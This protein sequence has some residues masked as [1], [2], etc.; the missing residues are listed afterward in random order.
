MEK[1][2]FNV[3]NNHTFDA[4]VYYLFSGIS[5]T[6]PFHTFGPAKRRDY[7]IHF[8]L[9][10]QG[11]FFTE[12][13]QF[14]LQAG[15]VFL[16]RP[17]ESCFYQS[18]IKKPWTYAWI[19]FNGNQAQQIIEHFSPFKNG[20]HVFNS[21]NQNKY[22]NIIQKTLN[23][24][25]ASPQSEL[26]LNHLVHEFL[27]EITQEY[28]SQKDSKNKFKGSNL[29]R[30][31]RE[32]MDE[33]FETGINVNDVAEALNINRSY[34]TRVFTN[35]FG[36][37]PKAWLIGVRINKAS[38]FLQMQD[39]SIDKISEIVGFNNVSVFSRSFNKMVGESPSQYRKNRQEKRTTNLNNQHIKDLL[40][41]AK[42]VRQTT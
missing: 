21:I 23:L 35:N 26:K 36:L 29:A 39:L 11:I 31:A 7:I 27:I 34:L 17:G 40:N 1:S 16:I 25:D 38:E 33:F 2:I 3:V 12:N 6:L 10:G 8:V 4:S 41:A 18:D 30:K 24:S 9:S 19:S 32:Y 5:Q 37:S 15:D 14:H 13:E 22:L 20:H 28:P 42:P